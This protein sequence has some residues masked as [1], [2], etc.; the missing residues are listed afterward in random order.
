MISYNN[1]Q[2]NVDGKFI[3]KVDF[4]RLGFLVHSTLLNFQFLRENFKYNSIRQ[5]TTAKGIVTTDR[6]HLV[7]KLSVI[8]YL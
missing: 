5:T 3:C 8:T 2:Y 7:D 6:G 4:P 1:H